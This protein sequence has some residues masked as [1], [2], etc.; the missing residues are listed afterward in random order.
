[1]CNTCPYFMADKCHNARACNKEENYM[2][3]P[4]RIDE[5]CEK[6]KEQWKRVPDWRFGQLVVNC[7]GQDPFY[8]E[9]ASAI[10]RIEEQLNKYM[11]E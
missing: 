7:L 6:L 3:D 9:D 8:V 10:K 1:M 5:F 2:R 4:K 11:G